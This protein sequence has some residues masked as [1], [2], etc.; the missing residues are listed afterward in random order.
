MDFC[1]YLECDQIKSGIKDLKSA[2]GINDKFQF[3]NDLFEGSMS[4]YNSFIKK[5][6]NFESKQKSFDY[7][8]EVSNQNKWS[9]ENETFKLFKSYLERRY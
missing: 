6:D 3:I 9:K 1:F 7:L 5:I 4:E 8:E 2:I